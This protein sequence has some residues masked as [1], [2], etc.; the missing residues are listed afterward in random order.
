[1]LPQVD[2]E[3]VV[4]PLLWVKPLVCG[5]S[6][7]SKSYNRILLLLLCCVVWYIQALR[8]E[9]LRYVICKALGS[10]ALA[11]LILHCEYV[12]RYTAAAVLLLSVSPRF[13]DTWPDATVLLILILV[14]CTAVVFVYTGASY[15][16]AYFE[17]ERK[18]SFIVLRVCKSVVVCGI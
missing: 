8:I 5:V 1:M 2:D 14:L 17:V 18:I 11:L 16:I 15:I 12:K 4:A 3:R 10:R 6:Y 9:L 13:S 7:A